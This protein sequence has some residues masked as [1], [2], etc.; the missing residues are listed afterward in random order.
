MI[1]MRDSFGIRHPSGHLE[2]KTIDLVVYGRTMLKMHFY[3][4]FGS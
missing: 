1:V 4:I 2:N 3:E